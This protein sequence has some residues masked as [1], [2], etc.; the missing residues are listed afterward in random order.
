MIREV[1]FLS[2]SIGDSVVGTFRPKL[3]LHDLI[4]DCLDLKSWQPDGIGVKPT[5]RTHLLMVLGKI[6]TSMIEVE[7]TKQRIKR[8]KQIKIAKLKVI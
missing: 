7:I 2:L 4:Q 8:N 1:A 6:K 3:F 5:W